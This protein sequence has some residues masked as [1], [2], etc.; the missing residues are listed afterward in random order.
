MPGAQFCD[1]R[2]Q[3][4]RRH[5]SQVPF[6][7]GTQVPAEVGNAH[8]LG[9]KPDASDAGAA[10]RFEPD[11]LAAKKYFRPERP[12]RGPERLGRLP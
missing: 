9:R 2:R 5:S 6:D 4:Q 3:L 11:T 8:N 12:E 7:R 10:I 1:P